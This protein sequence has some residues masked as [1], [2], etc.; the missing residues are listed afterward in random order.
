[1]YFQLDSA[2]NTIWHVVKEKKLSIHYFFSAIRMGYIWIIISSNIKE[3]NVFSLSCVTRPK[4]SIENCGH[5]RHPLCPAKFILQHFRPTR[6]E[7]IFVVINTMTFIALFS[8]SLSYFHRVSK[9]TLIYTIKAAL[10][11][12]CQKWKEIKIMKPLW[13]GMLECQKE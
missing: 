1:M 2:F 8:L 5:S 6:K 3:R 7:Y 13:N 9:E 12:V 10:Q 4:L 11:K